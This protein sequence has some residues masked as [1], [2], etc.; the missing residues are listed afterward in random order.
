MIIVGKKKEG[1]GREGGGGEGGGGDN[2]ANDS[3]GNNNNKVGKGHS[4]ENV[5][6]MGIDMITLHCIYV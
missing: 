4:E 5:E 1:G 6:E 2:G 3:D